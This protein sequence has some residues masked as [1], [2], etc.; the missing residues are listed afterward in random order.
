MHHPSLKLQDENI[1]VNLVQIKHTSW[2]GW[3]WASVTPLSIVLAGPGPVSC[4]LVST[5][6]G[7]AGIL[8]WGES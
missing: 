6:T 1:C 7:I 8:S 5:F 3:G 4:Q 2:T